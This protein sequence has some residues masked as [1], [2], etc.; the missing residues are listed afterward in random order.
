MSS[1][2]KNHTEDKCE[3]KIEKEKLIKAPFLY[4]DMNDRTHKNKG[5]G[6]RQYYV[7]KKC[8]K[9]GIWKINIY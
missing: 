1:Y 9:D 3:K 8:W 6:Y 7:C 2:P 4:L 5:R